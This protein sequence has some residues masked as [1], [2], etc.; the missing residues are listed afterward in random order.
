M[1]VTRTC[2][3]CRRE[4]ELCESHIIPE[5]VYAPLYDEGGKM[6]GFRFGE[7][8]IRSRLLQ[9]GLREPL[10]CAECEQLINHDYEQPNVAFWRSLAAH[11][12]ALEPSWTPFTAP[13]GDSGVFVRGADYSSFKLFLLSMLWRASVSALPEFHDV[14]L[15]PYEEPIRR[16]LLERSPGTKADY[17]CIVFLFKEP[18]AILP[19]KRQRANGHLM[20]HFILTTVQVWIF[21]SGHVSQERIISMA[22]REDGCFPALFMDPRETKLFKAMHDVERETKHSASVLRRFEEN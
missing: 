15:G 2:K 18:G 1:L 21:V 7:K 11:E 19:P 5:F 8:G 12:S 16:M 13:S 14:R 22:I 4:R 17:P 6:V 9:M 20:Y 3:L 10:L